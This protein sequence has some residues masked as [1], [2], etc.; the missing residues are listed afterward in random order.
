MAASRFGVFQTILMLLRRWRI[1]AYMDLIRMTRDFKLYLIN[2][3]SDTLLNLSGVAAV[4]L[5]VE[6]FDGIGDWS[7][8][9]V[10]FMLGYASLVTG[11]LDVLFSYNIMQISR[12]IGRGQFDHVMIQPQPVWMILLTEGFTPFSGGI[13]LLTGLGLTGW[14]ITQLSIDLTAVWWLWLCLNLFGSCAVVMGIAFF[15]G[16]FAFWSPVAAEEIS[17][18]ATRIVF[19]L[20]SFPLDGL[21]PFL[22]NT[23]LTVLP[24][25]FVAWYPS[26]ALLGLRENPLWM[27]QL[28]GVV[29]CMV[30]LLAFRQGLKQY[31]RTGSQRYVGWAHRS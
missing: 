17:S 2:V 18:Q 22:L 4:F 1:Q 19:Q 28:V 25:G 6:R 26:Q 27:T 10:I 15:W 31:E 30:A 12:R 23:L 7:P 5:I 3:V 16:T 13:S 21:A 8:P 24:V 11:I 20:K 14:A 29:A 9:Q